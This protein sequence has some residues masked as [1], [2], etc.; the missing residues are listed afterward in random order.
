MTKEIIGLRKRAIAVLLSVVI[1]FGSLPILSAFA[2]PDE[3]F[4]GFSGW[5]LSE[6][7]K[8]SFSGGITGYAA[9]ITKNS[10]SA[11]TLTSDLVKVTSNKNYGG[12]VF[13]GSDAAEA[14]AELSVAFF[15]DENGENPVSDTVI[16]DKITPTD[17]FS[18]LAGDFVVP[19]GA[20]YARISVKLGSNGKAGDVY[21]VDNAYI[22]V[23]STA[24]PIYPDETVSGYA[25]GEWAR[26]PDGNGKK[27]ENTS[28]RYIETV[29]DGYNGNGALH[30]VNTGIEGDMWLTVVPENVLAGDYTVSMKVKGSV[31]AAAQTFRF[32]PLSGIDDS[33][34]NIFADRLSYD[35]W[36]DFSYDCTLSGE[37]RFLFAFSQ[38]NG[39]SDVYIDSLKVTN[40]ATGEDVLKG[41]GDF[42]LNGGYSLIT[43]NNLIKNGDFEDIVYTYLSPES[44]NG[45]FDGAVVNE[46]TLSWEMD[47]NAT[48]DTLEIS[49]DSEH[50]GVLEMTK[51]ASAAAGAGWVTLSSPEIPVSSGSVYKFSADLKGTG[52]NPY[53]I[54]TAYYFFGNGTAPL[55]VKPDGVEGN[56]PD[57]WNSI[58]A[59]F[60]APQAAEKIQIRIVFQGAA[61]DK[62][63]FDNA[64]FCPL[65]N[66]PSLEHWTDTGYNNPNS[67][68]ARA[69][70]VESGY[71]G[72][73]GA[74]HF[75]RKFSE[76]TSGL[77]ASQMLSFSKFISGKTYV[78]EMSYKGSVTGDYDRVSVLFGWSFANWTDSGSNTLPLTENSADWKTVAKEFTVY[79]P[80]DVPLILSVGGYVDADC[81]FDNI[82]IYE[83]GDAQKTNLLQNGDFCVPSEPDTTNQL[84]RNGGFENMR[85][86]SAPGWSFLGSADYDSASGIITLG[87]SSSAVSCRYNVEAGQIFR[88]AVNGSGGK[89]KITFDNGRELEP[90][91]PG[92]IFIVP[93]GATY[94]RVSYIS[95]NGATVKAISLKELENP[96]NYD[97]EIKDPNS[98]RPLNWQSFCGGADQDIFKIKY[99]GNEGVNGSGA[100]KATA[101]KENNQFAVI[102]GKRMPANANGVYRVTFQG[103]YSGEAVKVYPY[104]RTYNSKGNDTSETSSY[105]WLTAA[106]SNN[107]DGEWHSYTADF[108]AGGDTA[109]YEM[110][111][112]IRSE[113]AGAEFLFDN[114]SVEY[115]GDSTNPNLDFE[116]GENG[117]KVFNWNM[118]ERRENPDKPGE[119]EEGSFGAYTAVKAE[120]ASYDGSAALHISKPQTGD[121][122]LYLQSIMLP[123][124][125]NTNYLLSYNAMAAGNKKGSLQICI[126]QYKNAGGDNV[127][128]ESEAFKWVTEAYEY[129]SFDWK[130]CGGTFKTS[131][132]AKFV[133]IWLV[134]NTADAM[135]MYI[136]NVAL[137]KTSEIDDPNLDFEYTAGGKP[138]NWSFAT[139]DGIAKIS[140]DKN[141]YYRGNNSLH[142]EKQYNRINYTTATMKKRIDVAAGDSI[143]FVIHIRSR[144]AVSG[145]FTASLSCYNSSGK[146]VQSWTGQDRTLNSGSSLSDW[147][148]Y[149]IPYTVGKNVR[150]VALTLRIGGRQ[151]DV[152]IDSVE[153]YNYTANNNTV[154]AEDFA[155]PSSDGM[156]GGFKKTDVNGNPNFGTSG[157]ATISGAAGDKA[158]IETEIDIIKTNYSYQFTAHY[159]TGGTAAGKLTLKGY[160][161]RGDFVGT[162]L[163]REISDSAV[164]AE[165]KADFTAIAAAFYR[166]RFEKTG[167]DGEVILS[168]VL[169]RNT[170]EPSVNL[171]WEGAW[172][173]HPA[174]YDTIESQLNNERYYYYRQE[175]NLE[176]SVK[177]A[178]MQIT[179]DD[180]ADLYI[181]GEKVYEET[182]TGDTW[183]LP[184]TLDIAEYLKKGKNV[185]A[186]RLYNGVYRYS[187]L[188]DG[189]VKMTND[190]VLRFY[191]DENV[192]VAR[193]VIG[194]NK[195]PNPQWTDF[196]ADNFMSPDYDMSTGGWTNA[197]IY[198]KVGSGGWGAIDFDFSEYS[199]YKIETDEFNFPKNTVYA[200]DTVDVTATLKISEKLPDTGS[201]KVYFWKRNSTSRICTG[202]I[203]LANGKTTESW[204]V[205]KEFTAEFEITVPQFLAA[206]D[207]TVQFDNSVAIVSDYFINNKVGNIKVAQYKQDV[208]TRSEIKV[209][210]GK[211]TVFVNGIAQAPL[212]YSRPERDTQF[213]QTEMEGLANVGI[214]TSIAFILP[215]ETLGE[216]WM[217]D[218][219]IKTETIDQQ[220]LGT[221]AANPSSQLVMA[222]D[223]T[224][225]QWWLDAHPE[226]CVKLNDGTVSKESFSSELWKKETGE[227]IVEIINY[228][229]EQPYANNIVGFKITGGTTY[230]WQ[231]WGINGSTKVGDYSSVG[232]SA[233]RSWLKAKYGTDAALRKAWGSN[234][235][236]LETAAVP[237]IAARSET[238]F[239]SILNA[240]NNRQAIDYELFMGE[241][242]TDAMLYFA[243]LV[244]KATDNRLIVG[245]Y[246]GYLLNV[247]N[248]DMAASTSQTSFQRILDSESIDFITCPWNY[249][250][251]EIGY[252]GDYMSAVDSVTAHGKLYIAED[253][254]RNHTTDM[255]D[256]PD[257]RASVGWTRTAEQSIEQLKRNFAYALSKGCGLYLYSLA[258]TYFTDEQ[259]WETASAMMQ[260]MTLS[261]G[262]ERRGV[263]DV[264]VFYDEQSA[265]YMPY[266]GSDLTNELLYK[267]L[268]LAQRKELYSLGTPYDTYLLDDLEKGLVPEHK[269]N[270]M[271][272]C[273]QV[274]DAERRAISEKLQK[275]GNVIIWIFTSG[276]SDG[277]TTSVE[278]LSALTGMNMKLIEAPAGERKLIGTVEVE[279]YDHWITEGLSDV[280]FGAIEYRTLAPVIAVEDQ[281]AVT[282]GYHTGQTGF[283]SENVGFAV[284]EMTDGNGNNWTSI[285]SA[286]PCVPAD[287]LRNILKHSGCHSYDETASD[288]IYADNSYISVHSLFG[289]EKT[290]SLPGSYTVYDVFN[291]RIIAENVSSFTYTS[292]KS[293]T[294]LFRISKNNKL[295]LYFT[296]TAGGKVTPE[297]LS[298]VTP[299]EDITLTF[300]PDSG[301]RLAYLL[302]DGVKTTVKGSSYTFSNI[303]ESHTVAVY[304]TRLYEKLPIDDGGEPIEPDTPNRNNNSNSYTPDN[305]G[306]NNGNGTEDEDTGRQAI[307]RKNTKY[308]TTV[309]LN[310][311][312]I[313]AIGAAA[314][315]VLAAVI[316]LL[317]L[318][319]GK[320]VVFSR[321]GKR[322]YSAKLRRGTVS[323]DRLNEKQGLS[324][325]TATVKKGYAGRHTGQKAVFTLNGTPYA[326][327][328]LEKSGENS[329][330]L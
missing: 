41:K 117:K 249:G 235:V 149:R 187:L 84:I 262:L 132:D 133:K 178:Q 93:D 195:T 63:L 71:N 159:R 226:E 317:V 142:I 318:L 248:Y 176:S 147:Q 29:E 250:E 157:E 324:G 145:S 179:A 128:D 170:A 119:F 308:Y 88:T 270:I 65:K 82:R 174:D 66:A 165:I 311:P 73:V 156:F 60:E 295:K 9:E 17:S 322:I 32:A 76:N 123:V 212:W 131:K 210:N 107:N 85:V 232:L 305:N 298:E 80:C 214:D 144:D 100:I 209:Y 289:G 49:S 115:L 296:R 52:S 276:M 121:V 257:A 79:S 201:F 89:L 299:G 306:G 53:Y 254:N 211:P 271:L 99:V 231:W 4:K 13:V 205:G 112:E 297:G 54:L 227:K 141:V 34:Y 135:D 282:L 120:N 164:S 185:I 130:N 293:E 310:L 48:G 116:I 62:M 16:L 126:R 290:I 274:T 92:G 86:V 57:G 33:K 151:S 175:I 97:F 242:K 256:A 18:E 113:K 291:R 81:Y 218:G 278:N 284:K 236:T 207:Y 286:V 7:D 31:A 329:V 312:V 2:E 315:A 83:K 173:V 38:Y 189:I 67:G 108:T 204:P 198:A 55:Q 118:Y 150:S 58:S 309:S 75:Y 243:G 109:F 19:A 181:N 259:L 143:E 182:R 129:G 239:G 47:N 124:E 138:L 327:V 200:G 255:F 158:A 328:V 313:I 273:T 316:I 261:L 36:T 74:L 15:S 224:P 72:S 50:G 5:T 208:S 77:S 168:D 87:S 103:K 28:T 114:I 265:A 234:T 220:I 68:S 153:Y 279:N 216:L 154:Y 37:N 237:S 139:S 223:T 247:I 161:W 3:T 111:F 202:T 30:I 148:E 163:E 251:R 283:G 188:Y 11:A 190:S 245:T 40:K 258:G 193:S 269:V 285:Y 26:Y 292:E 21:K 78:L 180:R 213:N 104:V 134:S 90:E 166:L 95:E 197:E 272:S 275:N 43:S 199:D 183:S 177:S 155:S 140:A 215:R 233:F 106:N 44:F 152:Y 281:S 330:K 221:L 264:A 42:C 162:V 301:Y 127:K 266:S 222:I 303:K 307:T 263:S 319:L 172:I 260:E 25:S 294:R 20:E 61:G 45:N 59:S 94:M 191:T 70:A 229:M 225:P 1:A 326:E 105:N 268:L 110:R 12:G 102:Y 27:W 304:Y 217:S 56:L 167:G 244:K 228:L 314:L 321:D 125:S 96:E 46:E 35:S 277:S 241:M 98:E 64:S 22:Y 137:T 39:A 230:E 206:G 101:E 51:G 300:E 219:S 194:E 203:T 69:E 267:G 136:D 186:V 302:I 160:N 238:E 91:M 184:V 169:I 24:L 171:G 8:L 192:K 14:D 10:G 253:D 146:L 288:V 246:A 196:D 323:L 287:I 6:K 23:Y 325:V 240:K 320:N 252:S 122:Q 280:S